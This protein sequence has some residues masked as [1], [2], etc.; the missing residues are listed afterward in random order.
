MKKMKMVNLQKLGRDGEAEG[1][2][3]AGP[4]GKTRALRQREALALS[5]T[6]IC[7]TRLLLQTPFLPRLDVLQIV[8]G[9][10]GLSQPCLW[11]APTYRSGAAQKG[12][13]S[14][15]CASESKYGDSNP[16]PCVLKPDSP[17][18]V[19]HGSQIRILGHP[20]AKV[21]STCFLSCLV[22]L[23]YDQDL[24]VTSDDPR[25]EAWITAQHGF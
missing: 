23:V 14:L 10:D 2:M 17:C 21:S 24:C 25:W 7:N 12:T 20:Q 6:A 13:A 16:H 19:G 22:E 11:A 3:E 4:P 1:A 15:R 18:V 8:E 5:T 9:E